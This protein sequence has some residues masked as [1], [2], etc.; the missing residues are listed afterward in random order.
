MLYSLKREFLV[1][2][3]AD[4][5]EYLPLQTH[6]FHILLSVIDGARHGYSIIREIGQRTNGD[7]MLGTSTLY[8]AIK[9]MVGTGLLEEAP[10]PADADSDDPRRRYY[11]ATELG[12]AVAREEALRIRQLNR[13]VTRTR[14]LEKTS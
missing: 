5:N 8:A 9:R 11:R 13:I 6:V 3:H 4:P 10:R 1:P 2:K 14:L 7:L 12:R